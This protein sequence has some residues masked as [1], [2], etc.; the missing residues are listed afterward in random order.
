MKFIGH[1]RAAS[2]AFREGS[3]VRME[4][5]SFHSA[6]PAATGAS[7]P[8]IT[9]PDEFHESPLG[10]PQGRSETK[11]FSKFIKKFKKYSIFAAIKV[12]LVVLEAV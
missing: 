6:H 4:P 1:A 5:N 10:K 7:L 9:V 12:W 11:N 3:V 2:L 8:G